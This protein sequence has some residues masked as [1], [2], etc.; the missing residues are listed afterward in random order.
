MSDAA[1]STTADRLDDLGIGILAAPYAA[2]VVANVAGR[3]PR[4]H[5]L[6]GG[7]QRFSKAFHARPAAELAGL[8]LVAP[9][10]VNPLAEKIDSVTKKSAAYRAGYT[11]A[12]TALGLY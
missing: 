3:Y 9:G 7:A 11:Y 6:R 8:A 5:G 12:H 1:H 4:L 10:V 2:D